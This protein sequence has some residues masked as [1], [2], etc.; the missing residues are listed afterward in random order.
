MGLSMVINGI[1]NGYKWDYKWDYKWLSNP[2][3]INGDKLG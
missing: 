1:I 3:G 2:F